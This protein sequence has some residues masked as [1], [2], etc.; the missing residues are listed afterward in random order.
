MVDSMV[1]YRYLQLFTSIIID[2]N[3]VGMKIFCCAWYLKAFQ[4]VINHITG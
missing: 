3:A 1:S 2:D 4:K